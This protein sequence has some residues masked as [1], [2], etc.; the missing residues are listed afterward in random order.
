MTEVTFSF[1][2]MKINTLVFI[3]CKPLFI[4]MGFFLTALTHVR[5]LSMQFTRQRLVIFFVSIYMPNLT[6]Q[7]D[8]KR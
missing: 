2:T 4:A 5:I 6:A 7:S 8:Y 3:A 1:I